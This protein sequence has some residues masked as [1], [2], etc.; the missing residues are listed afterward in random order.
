MGQVHASIAVRWDGTIASVSVDNPPSKRMSDDISHQLSKW[1]FEPAH[2][3]GH[4]VEIK[5]GFS[6]LLMCAGFPGRPETDRCTL[7]RSDEFRAATRITTTTV[8]Q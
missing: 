1:L 7:R 3:G 5:K 8:K 6:L 4:T 2:E